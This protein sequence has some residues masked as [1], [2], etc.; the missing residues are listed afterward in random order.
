MMHY[1]FNCASI[2]NN[3]KY[4][5]I[6]FIINNNMNDLINNVEKCKKI[7]KFSKPNNIDDTIEKKNLINYLLNLIC[8]NSLFNEIVDKLKS[9]KKYYIKLQNF[10]K[11]K[12]YIKLIITNS[13]NNIKFYIFNNGFYAI[14]KKNINAFFNLDEVKMNEINEL[15]KKC[16]EFKNNELNNSSSIDSNTN[17]S[18]KKVKKNKKNLCNKCNSIK[19]CECNLNND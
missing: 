10:Y 3:K 11:S 13:K 17:E 12:D 15:F 7:N 5:E 16:N 2:F 6:F 4:E 8:D 1:F 18:D 9:N 14:S 19:K